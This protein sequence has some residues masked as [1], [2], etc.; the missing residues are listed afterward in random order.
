MRSKDVNMLSGS[1]TKGLIAMSVPIMVM[2]VLQVLFNIIDMTILRYFGDD[3]SV[4]AVGACGVLISLITGLLIGI[5]VGANVVVAKRLGLGDEERVD[6]AATTSILFA[7]VGGFVLMVIGAVFAKTFLNMTNCPAGLLPRAT[8]YFTIY[9]FSVPALMFYNFGASILRATGDTKRPMYYLIIGGILKVVFTLIF[10]ALGFDVAGVAVATIISQLFAATSIFLRLL[11]IKDVV[12]VRFT[13]MK[14]DHEELKSILQVGVPASIQSA[15][16]SFANALI[17]TTVNGF[18]EAATTGI[19]IANQFDGILYHVSIAP[20]YAVTPYAAQN[21]GAGNFKR[22]K[23]IFLRAVLIT[24]AFAATFGLLSAIFSEQLASIMSSNPVVIAYARQKM[25]IISS[26][27]FICGIND[28]LGG[29][30][31]GIGRPNLPTVSTL[32]YMCAL[33]VVWVYFFFPLCP[34]L[35]FLYAVWPVGWCLSIATLLVPY[36]LTM[37]KL[38]ANAN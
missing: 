31:R 3:R 28:A 24:T 15:L 27:Y 30:L 25:I 29:V 2:N 4:G 21:M 38:E 18:G 36:F 7:I 34:N 32:V 37:K 11:K 20:S 1:I 9:F 8:Q 35:T 19:S 12:C 14:F 17:S 13:K 23:A 16:Y 10:A 26:T 33:R 6:N 22:I 5:S